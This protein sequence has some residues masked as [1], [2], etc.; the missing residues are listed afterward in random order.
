MIITEFTGDIQQEELRLIN[1]YNKL[2]EFVKN[3]SLNPAVFPIPYVADIGH[4]ARELIK[5]IGEL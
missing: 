1:N 4:S 3:I 2:L 5:E